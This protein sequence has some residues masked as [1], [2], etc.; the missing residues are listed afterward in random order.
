[1]EGIA[2][3]LEAARAYPKLTVIPGVEINTDI[4]GD[5]VHILGYFVDYRDQGLKVVLE[6]LRGTR[7]ERAKGMIAKLAKLGIRLEWRRVRQLAGDGSV[8]RPHVAQAMLEAGY[9]STLGEAFI[10]YI[11]R[12]GPAYVERERMTP[13]EAVQLVL[14]VRGLPV[15]AHP[16]E[17]KDRENLVRELRKAGLVGLEAYYN[18]Y[19]HQTMAELSALAGREGLVLTGGTDYHGL[20]GMMEREPGSVEVPEE[21][22]RSFL[23]LAE[24][25]SGVR[26]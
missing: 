19:S 7:E 26:P 8:G 17:L 13:A 11:G 3:A 15:L 22:V 14:K 4:P 20:E 10:K 16:A 6:R 2:P 21:A 25:G 12:D 18:G 5:E 1:M 23:L 24:K 9:I